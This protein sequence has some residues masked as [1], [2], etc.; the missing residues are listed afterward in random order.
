MGLAQ[1]SDE[2]AI[3]LAATDY[4]ENHYHNGQVPTK[5]VV[6]Y[7]MAELGIENDE[8]SRT[9]KDGG[10]K[11]LDPYS[12]LESGNRAERP[13]KFSTVTVEIL[14]MDEDMA[15]I[16]VRTNMPDYY[17]YMHLTKTDGQWEIVNVLWDNRR[18]E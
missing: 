14:D 3:E 1:V 12:Q 6:R 17:D 5:R 11:K 15:S 9:L 18:V 2:K 7:K 10:Y 16:G 8:V 13:N 4:M